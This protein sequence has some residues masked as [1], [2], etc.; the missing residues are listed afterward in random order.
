MVVPTAIVGA[1]TQLETYRFVDPSPSHAATV[2]NAG[3]MLWLRRGCNKNLPP[4][5]TFS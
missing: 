2:V 3:G 4:L 1:E 5:Q